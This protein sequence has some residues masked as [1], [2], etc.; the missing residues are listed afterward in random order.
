MR[1]PAQFD[2]RTDNDLKLVE[3]RHA[4]IIFL[5][6]TLLGFFFAAQIY[7]SAALTHREVSWAQALYWALTDWYEFALLAPIILWTCRRF[8][9]ERGSWPRALAVHFCVGLLLAGVHVVLCAM[10]DVFQGWFTAKPV[11]F[12]KSLRG[13]LYNRT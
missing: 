4:A 3:R 7:F 2:P 13:I 5:L 9:F 1:D 8:R 10:S 6:A 11:V 12:A